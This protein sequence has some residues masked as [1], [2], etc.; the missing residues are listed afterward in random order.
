VAQASVLAIGAGSAALF[1]NGRNNTG[2][3]IGGTLGGIA[4]SFF[5]PIGTIVGSAIGSAIGSLF[6]SGG[7]PKG[8]G[9][10]STGNVSALSFGAGNG[11]FYTPN[12]ADSSLSQV[13][14]TENTNFG[15]AYSSLGGK[16]TPNVG[17]ALGYDTDPNGT[18]NNRVSAGATVN[19]KSVYQY[20]S[21]DNAL[22]RSDAVLQSTL[23]LEAKRALLAALQA[24]DLPKDVADILKG[25]DPATATEKAIDNVLNL[26][27]AV[28]T[29]ADLKLPDDVYQRLKGTLGP[30][31]ENQ[32]EALTFG[33]A[34]S[35]AHN[36]ELDDPRAAAVARDRDRG[37]GA[38][39]TLS[40]LIHGTADLMNS[41]DGTADAAL[42]LANASVTLK[43][44]L[45]D[46]MM[47]AEQVKKSLHDMFDTRVSITLAVGMP[48]NQARYN[49]FQSDA[50]RSA[51]CSPRP[52]IR[53]RFDRIGERI[54]RDINS[55][56]DLLSPEQQQAQ[57]QEFIDGLNQAD[58]ETGQLD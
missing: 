11:R 49:Y 44:G 46:A 16:G 31:G 53:R 41:F 50:A 35:V 42:G 23:T 8:G 58:T 1:G 39:G 30:A 55:A 17:F 51:D 47:Q 45:I 29:L 10:A 37:R 21:G 14:G 36:T 40:N 27:K 20:Y 2:M 34:Y 6:N 38:A 24:S 22:G 57:W 3:T 4:G 54:N 13:L 19:G 28:K 52:P 5:G 33:Q 56:F 15:Q 32:Q 18:A 9:S 12:T 26:A 25:I 48:D 7:G 43:Q